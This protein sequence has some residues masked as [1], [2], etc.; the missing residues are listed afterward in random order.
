MPKRRYITTGGAGYVPEINPGA[1]AQDLRN[2]AYKRVKPTGYTYD[3]AKGFFANRGRVFTDPNTEGLWGMYTGQDSIVANY[4]QAPNGMP[5]GRKLTRAEGIALGLS[6]EDPTIEDMA[7]YA[8]K[9]IVI[10]SRSKEGAYELAYPN[11]SGNIPHLPYNSNDVSNDSWPHSHQLGTFHQIKGQDE[12]GT[13]VVYKDTWDINPF[14][15]Q[16]SSDD[17]SWGSFI[18]AG[19]KVGL[20]K[21]GD[22]IPFGKPFEVYGKQY[23]DEKGNPIN[24][25]SEG[26]D[27]KAKDWDDLSMAEKAEIMRIAVEGGVQDLNSI[28]AGYNEY[29]KGGRIYIKPENRGK[30]TALK[31]RT[32]HSASWFK[33]HGTPA[34]RKMATF[35]LN[36]RKW[37]HEDGGELF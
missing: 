22:L 18:K 27:L 3:N 36:A 16:S 5:M 11:Q 4:T 6:S 15:G 35:A 8:V 7:K 23:Y 30:F 17:A 31:K 12:N 21:V 37:K 10:P 28:K 9:D 14:R 26:G 33:A 20:D 13:Y 32:G 34:Q 19:R 25:K 1:V 2:S 29:A 24:V